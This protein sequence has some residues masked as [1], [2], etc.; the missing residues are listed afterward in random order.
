M[1]ETPTELKGA[2]D[3]IVRAGYEYSMPKFFSSVRGYLDYAM[4]IR[5][6]GLETA[7]T[8]QLALNAD[9]VVLF[10][11][12]E[13]F[14]LGGFLGVGLGYN[15]HSKVAMTSSDDPPSLQSFHT[16]L[17][18]GFS[19]L[20]MQNHRIELGLKIPTYTLQYPSSVYTDWYS[21]VL[22]DYMF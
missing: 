17:N 14:K 22:Y 20:I 18:F 5:P 7:T 15:E 6:V 1:H 8:S 16:L 3:Y 9:I 13:H 10:S 12:I 4:S 21:F 19:S 2:F 11:I